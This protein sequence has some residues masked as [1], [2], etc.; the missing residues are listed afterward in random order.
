MTWKANAQ[1]LKE[2]EGKTY[3]FMGNS[4]FERFNERIDTANYTSEV[5]YQDGKIVKQYYPKYQGELERTESYEYNEIGKIKKK[6]VETKSKYSEQAAIDSTIYRYKQKEGDCDILVEVFSD[7]PLEQRY[8]IIGDTNF[9]DEYVNGKY[10]YT[11]REYKKGKMV[12]VRQ[13]IK[14]ELG[15]VINTFFYDDFG[16]ELR[17][18]RTENGETEE[19]MKFEYKFDEF[20]RI[21][22]KRTYFEPG[23]SIMSVEI[24]IYE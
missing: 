22:E 6:V 19:T 17:Y 24:I 14:P 15:E 3:L 18:E 10:A 9:I 12:K 1:S 13:I 7:F 21:I 11:T 2:Y 20:N 23:H 4:F 5:R 16:N 8:T